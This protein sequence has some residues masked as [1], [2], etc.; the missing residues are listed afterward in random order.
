MFERVQFRQLKRGIPQMGSYFEVRAHCPGTN[1]I[2]AMNK[3]EILCR[4]VSGKSSISF[5]AQASHTLQ[6]GVPELSSAR[7]HSTMYSP[8]M[9]D[10]NSL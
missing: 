9:K 5:Y 1:F 8:E 10:V 6:W 2:P 3:V 4:C 7:L